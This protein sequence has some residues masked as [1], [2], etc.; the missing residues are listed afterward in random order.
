MKASN[1]NSGEHTT[2][3]IWIVI[4]LEIFGISVVE[5]GGRRGAKILWGLALGAVVI[6]VVLG[7]LAMPLA[8]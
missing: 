6:V 2:L 3:E 5:L 4:L 7:V 8:L 1:G